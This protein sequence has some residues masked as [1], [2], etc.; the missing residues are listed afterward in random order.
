VLPNS[1]NNIKVV[2]SQGEARFNLL[3]M[4][5]P[6]ISQVGINYRIACRA[7][8]NSNNYSATSAFGA[9]VVTTIR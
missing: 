6:R 4:P 1:Q 3:D 9:I 2:Q 7:L 8:D 5:L